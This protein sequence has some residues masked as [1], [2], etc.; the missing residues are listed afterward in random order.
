MGGAKKWHVMSQNMRWK[1]WPKSMYWVGWG[2]GYKKV[3][4]FSWQGTTVSV[5]S[6]FGCDVLMWICQY[7]T[8]NQ[9]IHASV[10][11]HVCQGWRVEVNLPH[12]LLMLFNAL[13]MVFKCDWYSLPLQ[14][15]LDLTFA[16]WSTLAPA[17]SS[18]STTWSWPSWLAIC[19]AVLSSCDWDICS[20]LR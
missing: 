2:N 17:C 12:C 7:L 5:Q 4:I 10:S 19:S 11:M 6:I 18:S 9:S 8:L 14:N 13:V 20:E 16:S 1:R 15:N 3:V